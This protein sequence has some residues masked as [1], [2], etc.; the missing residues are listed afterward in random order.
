[1]LAVSII[2]KHHRELKFL[3]IV[4]L[5]KSENTGCSLLAA[6]DHSWNQIPVLSVHEIDKIS[7]V[8]DDDVRTHLE[9]SSDMCLILLRSS[10]IPC[11]DIETGLNESRCHIVLSRERVASCNVHFCTTGCKN[12]AKICGLGLKV[13]R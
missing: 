3:R 11:E 2:D 1:M 12:L 9:D 8:I 4:Q 6:S 13:N 10:I 7:A 5:D